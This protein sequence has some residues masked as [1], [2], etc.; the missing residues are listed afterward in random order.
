M[1]SSLASRRNNRVGAQLDIPP[2]N[3][4]LRTRTQLLH[5][6]YVYMSDELDCF[7]LGR[8]REDYFFVDVCLRHAFLPFFV[9]QDNSYLR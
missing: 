5:E 1:T 3:C 6:K 7:G 8:D 2:F 4:E 9:S